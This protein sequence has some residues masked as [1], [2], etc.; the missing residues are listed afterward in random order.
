MMRFIVP[1]IMLAVSVGLFFTYTSKTYT[2]IQDLR[3]KQAEYSDAL[4]NAAELQAV[5]NQLVEKYNLFDTETLA[6]LKKLLPDNVDNIKLILE[7][8]DVA[9]K[10]GMSL[11]NVKFQSN[12][13]ASPTSI[14]ESNARLAEKKKAYSAFNVEFSTE[15]T[16][17]NFVLFIADLEKSLR[18]V[19]VNSIAFSSPE[20]Q[21]TALGGVNPSK[22]R[23]SYKY[24]FSVATYWL[25]Q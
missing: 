18:I 14:E 19:D 13:S 17:S 5:R 6:E 2:D 22:P 25:K 1:L 15:G 8:N 20:I 11:K 24:D 4:T 3:I 23:D 12:S 10:Y 16:Y 9:V 7:I 21:Q